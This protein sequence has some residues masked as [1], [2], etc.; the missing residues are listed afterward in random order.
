MNRSTILFSTVVLAGAML[1]APSAFAEGRSLTIDA[2]THV[3]L[4]MAQAV[5]LAESLVKGRATD[6]RLSQ[7]DAQPVYR[8]TVSAP[9]QAPTQVEVAHTQG[10]VVAAERRKD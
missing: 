8:V 6:V 3:Q 10:R 2:P 9:G 4:T 7:H 5:V 1:A